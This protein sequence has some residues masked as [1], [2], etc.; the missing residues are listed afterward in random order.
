MLVMNITL[1]N[2]SGIVFD[3]R[4][5]AYYTDIDKITLF[6]RKRVRGLKK[7]MA[8]GGLVFPG[9]SAANAIFNK[10]I[11]KDN[12]GYI[13][14]GAVPFAATY[15]GLKMNDWVGVTYNTKRN[16]IKPV[17]YNPYNIFR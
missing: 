2:D 8:F 14:L 11:P 1:I 17:V 10:N 9:V 13:A 5:F 3:N 15:L 4:Y 6:P 7:I 12:L 16:R